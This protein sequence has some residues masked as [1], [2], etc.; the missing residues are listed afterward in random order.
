MRKKNLILASLFAVI[1]SLFGCA[2]SV[3]YGDAGSAKP[4]STDFGSSD[5]Q[6]VSEAMVDSLMTFP[7]L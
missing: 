1:L 4:L 6:Q 2:T 3:Q 7:P 5:L